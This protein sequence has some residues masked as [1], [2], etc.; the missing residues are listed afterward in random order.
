MMS[1]WYWLITA[2]VSEPDRRVLVVLLPALLT[3]ALKKE[4]RPSAAESR[5]SGRGHVHGNICPVHVRSI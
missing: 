4:G 2:K 3:T 1:S 5:Q